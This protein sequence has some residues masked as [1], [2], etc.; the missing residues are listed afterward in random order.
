MTNERITENH[1]RK[2]FQDDPL[3]SS[4]K[5]EEQKSSNIRIANCLANASKGGGV[6]V[7]KIAQVNQSLL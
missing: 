3:F 1:V 2:H 4:I 5:F 7:V 6:E